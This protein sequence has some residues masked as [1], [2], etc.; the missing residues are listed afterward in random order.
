MNG[1]GSNLVVIDYLHIRADFCCRRA[2][3]GVV[4]YV[5]IPLLHHPIGVVV[6]VMLERLSVKDN[7]QSL[8]G[9]NQV[10]D[11]H[12]VLAKAAHHRRIP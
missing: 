10:Q 7:L 5:Q 9:V 8:E 3:R 11:D 1:S 4:D 2:G 6:L 12:T